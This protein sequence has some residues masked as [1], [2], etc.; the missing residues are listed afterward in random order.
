[1][2]HF[3]AVTCKFQRYFTHYLVYLLLKF[4][5]PTFTS[6]IF[7]DTFQGSFRELHIFFFNAVGFQFFGDK[8]PASYFYFFFCD[9]SADFYQ[10]HTVQ[11]S[12]RD[13]AQIVCRSDEHYFRQVVIYIQIVIVESVVLFGV[14][15]FQHSGTGISTVVTAQFVYFVQNDNRIRR[16]GFYQTFDD[17]ARHGTD[18][19]FTMA[20]DLGF[21]M[22]TTQ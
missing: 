12:R 20:T 16:L 6:I 11:Q 22:H 5:Y 13:G 18:I 10:L 15:H 21:V 1:M 17:T 2:H 19:S 7:Y 14:K 3:I 8:M 9:I 4:A